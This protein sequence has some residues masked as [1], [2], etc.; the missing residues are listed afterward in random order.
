MMTV[1]QN[2]KEIIIHEDYDED[3]YLATDIALLILE[4]PFEISET[5]NVI[6]LPPQGKLFNLKRC[7]AIGWGIIT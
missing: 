3:N 4:K 6:C 7:T 5:I 2:I 1:D